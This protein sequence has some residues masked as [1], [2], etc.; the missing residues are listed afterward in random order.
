MD[1]PF[2]WRQGWGIPSAS[3]LEMDLQLDLS[4]NL[5]PLHIAGFTRT[6][7]KKQTA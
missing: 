6:T 2:K 1:N 7:A 4:P 3:A 5:N